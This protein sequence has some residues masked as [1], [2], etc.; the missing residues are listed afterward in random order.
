MAATGPYDLYA[1]L[2]DSDGHQVAQDD[3]LAWPA[4]PLAGALDF[5][6]TH[7]SAD[8]LLT[9]Y[10]LEARPG[11]Y[12]IEVGAVHRQ[13]PNRAKLVGAPIGHMARIPVTITAT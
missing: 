2:M 8:R 4:K 13:E 3:V 7:A 10:L 6:D 5:N 11:Q 1:H 9:E 12:E